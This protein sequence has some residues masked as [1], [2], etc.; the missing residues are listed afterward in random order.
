[1]IGSLLRES[2]KA[3]GSV[4]MHKTFV[5]CSKHWFYRASPNQM[6]Y[7]YQP[8]LGTSTGVL[9][10]PGTSQA[11]AFPHDPRPNPCVVVGVVPASG[12][13]LPCYPMRLIDKTRPNERSRSREYDIANGHASP[14]SIESLSCV[15]W[16]FESPLPVWFSNGMPQHH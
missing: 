11:F 12:M 2:R 14:V 10:Q 15:L 4:R 5:L 1:M 16:E 13:P 3:Q 6:Q 7:S 8:A 9:L